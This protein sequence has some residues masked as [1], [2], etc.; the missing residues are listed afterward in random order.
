M[1]EGTETEVEGREDVE[2]RKDE[3]DEANGGSEKKEQRRGQPAYSNAEMLNSSG[4]GREGIDF[5]WPSPAR[6]PARPSASQ[7]AS[8]S[9]C[10]GQMDRTRERLRG[11]GHRQ[12]ISP[13]E[14]EREICRLFLSFTVRSL[15]LIGHVFG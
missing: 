9:A 11:G 14:A 6:P 5:E 8:Q 15:G 10:Q 1:E 2:R 13:S 7:P 12:S 3:K 4:E